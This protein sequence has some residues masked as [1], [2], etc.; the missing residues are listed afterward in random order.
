MRTWILSAVTV[1]GLVGILAG[2]GSVTRETVTL[3]STPTV[4]VTGP[5]NAAGRVVLSATDLT[6]QQAEALGAFHAGA[7]WVQGFNGQPAEVSLRSNLTAVFQLPEPALPG[8]TF[9]LWSLQNGRWQSDRTVATVG[10][11]GRAS[12]SLTAW[13]AF[14]LLRSTGDWER[15]SA[16]GF[17]YVTR[18][19]QIPSTS[20]NAPQVLADGARDSD[21]VIEAVMHAT[22][23]DRSGVE[24]LLSSFGADRVRVLRSTQAMWVVR[25][26]GPDATP[27]RW[28]APVSARVEPPDSARQK[29]ALPDSN[30]AVACVLGRVLPGVTLIEGVC[31]DMTQDPLFGPYATGGGQQFYIPAATRWVVDHPE[32]NPEAFVVA[33]QLRIAEIPADV[34]SRQ[35]RSFDRSL[36]DARF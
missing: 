14:S 3:A 15:S 26:Y 25:Y 4:T 19:T 16:H 23:R 24:A 32:W 20:L 2:C 6:R 9:E 13:G 12:A 27:G 7:M 29:L 10:A 17:T 21:A 36:L 35:H 31:A 30:K 22:G 28:F 8:W 11:D 5:E 34:R 33:A 18:T 1:L